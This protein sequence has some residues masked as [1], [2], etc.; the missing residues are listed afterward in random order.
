MNTLTSPLSVA[1]DSLH[2]PRSSTADP[3]ASQAQTSDL[4][5]HGA[6]YRRQRINASDMI[7][8]DEAAERTG[9]TRV[10]I[11]AW[12]KSGRCVGVAHLRRGFKVPK[13]QFEPWVFPVIQSLSEALGTRDG[14]SL[15]SFLETPH[16]ALDGW[17]P[18]LALEQGVP[19]Q[20]IVDLATAQGH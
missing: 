2:T 8:T 14:W 3:Y 5:R 4:L 18:R 16:E 10:T 11:N 20:R 9:T 1:F 6:E 13:W 7:T 17:P 12:I 15:L 19:G